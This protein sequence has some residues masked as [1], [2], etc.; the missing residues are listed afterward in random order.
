MKKD[1]ANTVTTYSIYNDFRHFDSLYTKCVGTVE[2]SKQDKR[3]ND[4]AE[5]NLIIDKA[6]LSCVNGLTSK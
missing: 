3:A 4:K 1:F 5:P 2:V 6:E